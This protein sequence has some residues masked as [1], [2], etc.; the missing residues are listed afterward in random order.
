[1]NKLPRTFCITLKETPLRTKLF[2]EE[3]IKTGIQ[4][5]IFNGIFGP[6]MKLTPR[7]TNELECPGQNIYMTD[8]AVGCYLSH[9]ML[10][11]V[12]LYQPDD[13]FLILEDD[14]IF[15]DGFLEKFHSVYS[16]LPSNWKMAY[17]GW[18]PY[19]NDKNKIV[20]DEGI[21]IKQPSATHAYLI[22]KSAL[23]LAC[24]SIQPCCSPLDLTIGAKFLSCIKFY[25]FDPPLITQRSYLNAADSVWNSLVYDWKS[26]L[27]GVKKKILKKLSLVEGWHSIEKTENDS[28]R[29]SKDKFVINVPDAADSVILVCSTPVENTVQV[30]QGDKLLDFPLVIGD[31]QIEIVTNLPDAPITKI[32]ANV[33]IPFIP[34]ERDKKSS[35]SRVLGIC[36]KKIIVNTATTKL[37]VG[38]TELSAIAPP[39]LSFKL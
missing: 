30:K 25:V 7:L 22:K 5:I 6:Q 37:E 39:S 3:A 24:D 23:K 14:A 17:V 31:N 19:G 13:E 18:L 34:F 21:C 33:T 35:D 8:G 16:R 9:Y 11:N 10:W 15:A 1:M 20:V 26:D 12:L 32:E 38:V 27:Y 4:P 36:L 2:L 28:W 29:W